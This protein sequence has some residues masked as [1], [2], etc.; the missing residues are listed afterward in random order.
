M[1]ASQNY[2]ALSPCRQVS[3]ARGFHGLS[4]QAWFPTPNSCCSDVRSGRR[5]YIR[6]GLDDDRVVIYVRT[7]HAVANYLDPLS[8]MQDNSH[9]R[10]S[11]EA[12][13]ERYLLVV[14][15]SA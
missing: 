2:F 12:T 3:H 15:K 4:S 9:P 10:K 11:C 13:Q 6:K 14:I 8:Q 1:Y 7:S 5:L